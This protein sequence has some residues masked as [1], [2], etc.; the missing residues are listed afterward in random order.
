MKHFK[1]DTGQ[2]HAVEPDC[3]QDHLIQEGW[4]P[5]DKPEP[6]ID[7]LQKAMNMRDVALA[8]LVHDF[9]NGRIIQVRPPQFAG[10]AFNIDT[11]IEQMERNGLTE[12][13]WWMLDNKLHTITLDELKTAKASGQDQGVAI[14]EQ[15]AADI[16]AI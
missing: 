15:F 6:V 3:S 11:A 13:Q 12:R 16:A 10:D 4:T 9:S 5:C 2:I 14:W 8:S 1:D 7:P